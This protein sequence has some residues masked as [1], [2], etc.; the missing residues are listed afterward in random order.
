[1]S[2]CSFDQLISLWTGA[3][4]FG[5]LWS[6][7][8]V[9]LFACLVLFIESSGESALQLVA[10]S[11]ARVLRCSV[12]PSP[13]LRARSSGSSAARRRRRRRLC[14]D[15]LGSATRQRR[16]AHIDMT[17]EAEARAFPPVWR[18]GTR[19]WRALRRHSDQQRPVKRGQTRLSTHPAAAVRPAVHPSARAPALVHSRVHT[20][21]GC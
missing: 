2:L 8:S 19:S 6:R 7:W 13:T 10:V 20:Y 3:S 12:C 14:S 11:D 21:S 15:S 4:R 18:A 16:V 17:A 1:M 5:P 9:V